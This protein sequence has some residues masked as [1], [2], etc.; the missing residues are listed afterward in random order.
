MHAQAKP[1]ESLNSQRLLRRAYLT[2]AAILLVIAVCV[3]P[4]LRAQSNVTF[5][6]PA[7]V[8]NDTTASS[9]QLAVDSAGNAYVAYAGTSAVQ[10]NRTLWIVRGTFSG[11]IFRPSAPPVEV[12]PDVYDSFDA[13]SIVAEAPCAIDLAYTTGNGSRPPNDLFLAQS[14]DCGATFTN[15]NI[16][17]NM[18]GYESSAPHL[19]AE[20]GMVQIVWVSS[21]LHSLNAT[22]FFA[23]RT[24]PTSFT[25]PIAVG[26]SVNGIYG[27]GAF[28]VPSTGNIDIGWADTD[29]VRTAN[30]WLVESDDG[31]PPILIGSGWEPQLAGDSAGN[32]YVSLV[33]NVSGTIGWELS[34]STGQA[35][36][37]TPPQP[38][39]PGQSITVAQ[40]A[41]DANGSLNFLMVV[42]SEGQDAAGNSDEE[43][44]LLFSRSM[45]N[46]N[47]F[48]N[49]VPI[50][51]YRSYL[52]GDGAFAG[53]AMVVHS[54]GAADVA[55]TANSDWVRSG[56]TVSAGGPDFAF[57][58][59]NDEGT[60]F[61]A[62]VTIADISISAYCCIAIT[63]DSAGHTLL[64]WQAI[65][66]GVF[67]TESSA[68]SDFTI[69]AA[70]AA[71]SVLP[72][73][74]ANFTLT[75][76][77]SGGFSNA[78]N[79]TCTNLPPG[80]ACAFN[81]ASITPSSSGSNVTLAIT[82]PPT[83]AQGNYSVTI[84]AA[85]GDITQTQIVQVA[86]GGIAGSVA[87]TSA[88][89]AVGSSAAFAV[90]LNSTGGFSGQV[91]L[92]CNGAP[93]G[94]SCNFSP[95]QVSV[96]ANGNANSTL[97][98]SV[99]SQPMVSMASPPPENHQQPLSRDLPLVSALVALFAALS[100]FS[101]MRRVHSQRRELLLG[102]ACFAAVLVLA[103]GLISCG[104]ATTAST[105]SNGSTGTSATGTTGTSGS[106]GG[107]GG[108]G[109]SGGSGSGGSGSGGSGG[110]AG[111]NSVTTQITVQAQSGGATVNV[112]SISIT[113]P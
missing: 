69:T 34:R 100:A 95:A 60:V 54:N 96:A 21:A 12:S 58:R 87:P 43:Q 82:A 79:L 24:S 44:T 14:T 107:T 85:S 62:P 97:T 89:V 51:S 41:V 73:G 45:D 50:V 35:G 55:W 64:A 40:M 68:V 10:F 86:V 111:G 108:S 3:E 7:N 77:A 19:F 90:S 76:T 88:T 28:A 72:G 112:G 29:D 13:F 70:P 33:G 25:T 47:T 27:L 32:V 6:T 105:G 57:S 4:P 99:A 42:P 16:T 46:A 103:V 78:A 104:G 65:G 109:G 98:V 59:S 75:L 93:S 15:T 63:T 91:N 22:I 38:L 113:V 31:T 67:V 49:P 110:S 39:F 106:S 71:Q 48:S 23:Q 74:A 94:V 83:L 8:S 101:A 11:S 81:S 36:Q 2:P 56:A 1:R 61:S 30:I 9:P 37:F 26:S 84:S 92:A 66:N 20:N 17:N 53:T 102:L 52:P 18:P 80:A 5:T